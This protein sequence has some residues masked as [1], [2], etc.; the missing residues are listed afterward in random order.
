[1]VNRPQS[2]KKGPC[3]FKG[4]NILKNLEIK[5]VRISDLKDIWERIFNLAGCPSPFVSYGWFYTLGKCLLEKDIEVMVFY[6]D[7]EAVGILPAEIKNYNLS[8]IGDERVTD[9]NGGIFNPVYSKKIFEVL[10][11]N[12]KRRRVEKAE[13]FSVLT[14]PSLWDDYI[15]SLSSKKRHELRRKLAKSEGAEIKRL[16]SNDIGNLFELM[17]SSSAEKKIFLSEEMKYFFSTLA[18]HFERMG[19]LR[20]KGCFYKNE[21]LAIL[22]CFQLKDTVY[23][24]NTGYNPDFYKLSPGVVSFAL[25]IEEAIGEGFTCYNF[26]R[27][28]ERF[29][30]D[31]GARRAYTWKI[32]R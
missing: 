32:K 20:L 31:L 4:V 3:I 30:S 22:F 21:I 26:L 25:D 23:A 24:F 19:A 17:E 29:K 9:I 13:P 2:G 15:S 5:F 7:K 11:G 1:M 16:K 28:E 18:E 10:S 6:D 14:L 12:L 27:G 8:L